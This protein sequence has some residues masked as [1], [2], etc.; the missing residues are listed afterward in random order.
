MAVIS[1]VEL[2]NAQRDVSDLGKVVNGAANLANPSASAPNNVG[3]VTTRQGAL[4]KTLSKLV[5]D[6][7]DT[8]E[9]RLTPIIYTSTLERNNALATTGVNEIK[10]GRTCYDKQDTNLYILVMEDI[11]LP[12]VATKVWAQLSNLELAAVADF[13]DVLRGISDVARL[14]IKD[15]TFLREREKC[16]AN[17]ALKKH[18]I[19]W[20]IKSTTGE[21]LAKVFGYTTPPTTHFLQP[22]VDFGCRTAFEDLIDAS[23]IVS[24]NYPEWLAPTKR[25]MIRNDSPN[26]VEGYYVPGYIEINS[27]Y[28]KTVWVRDCYID[29]NYGVYQ[30]VGKNNLDVY[31]TYVEYCTIRRFLNEAVSLN[32][33]HMAYCDI[34]LS[35]ADGVK[36]SGHDV[37]YHGNMFRLLGQD[38]P[39]THADC[40]QVWDCSRLYVTGN[41]FYM[42]GT[43]TAYDEGTYGSTQVIR[44]IT[45][46]GSGVLEDCYVCGN[47]CIGGGFSFA[48]RARFAGSLVQNVVIA[49]NVVGGSIAGDRLYVY[50]PI[51]KEHWRTQQ[52]GTLRNLI[53]WNNMMHDGTGFNT[54]LITAQAGPNQNGLWHYDKRY[55]TP[56]FLECGKK[57]GLLDWNGDPAPGVTVQT[58]D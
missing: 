5:A 7:Y 40:L 26:H 56:E 6:G 19:Q 58:G 10:A 20:P 23:T 25:I 34:E 24:P 53:F 17:D 52:V 50:G 37:Y 30:G 48:V 21:G 14:S 57:F 12:P 46:S 47:I 15:Y 8:V 35:R 45:E 49:N 55:A 44:L 16:F 38:V 31:P 32:Y 42:P 33:G 11:G 18:H 13:G 9:A 2:E 1:R 29:G 51:T 27:T 4:I 28:A 54:E 41:T 43:A 39:S 3:T 36:A 22:G